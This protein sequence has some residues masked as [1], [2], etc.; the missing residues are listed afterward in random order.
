[1]QNKL[2]HYEDSGLREVL[3]VTKKHKKRSKPLDLKRRK[4]YHSG[5]VFWSLRKIREACAREVVK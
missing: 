4:K 2:L 5:A 1:V 3:N